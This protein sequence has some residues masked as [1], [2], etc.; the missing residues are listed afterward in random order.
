ME[1]NNQNLS[2][3]TPIFSWGDYWKTFGVLLIGCFFFGAVELVFLAFSNRDIA[4]SFFLVWYPLFVFVVMGEAFLALI[5]SKIKNF[6]DKVNTYIVFIL[7]TWAYIALIYLPMA[8]FMEVSDSEVTSVLGGM[9]P[10]GAFMAV[11]SILAGVF[12]LFYGLIRMR[13]WN[14]SRRENPDESFSLT[15]V[16][17]FLSHATKIYVVLAILVG[18]VQFLIWISAS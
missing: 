12:F 13:R 14:T 1:T 16:R 5:F 11:M 9:Y 18:L 8:W 6:A 2:V 17:W 3:A 10:N 15:F 4:G 7:H